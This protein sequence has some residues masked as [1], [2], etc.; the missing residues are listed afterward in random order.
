MSISDEKAEYFIKFEERSIENGD[1]HV[2]DVFESE[3]E[4]GSENGNKA[5]NIRRVVVMK[6][7]KQIKEIHTILWDK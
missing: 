6:C 7:S 2:G 5:S 1:L 4:S 3:S